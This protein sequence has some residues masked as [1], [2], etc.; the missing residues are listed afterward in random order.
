VCVCVRRVACCSLQRG[1]PGR[2]VCIQL[3]KCASTT[4][5]V[6]MCKS[7][8]FFLGERCVERPL[9]GT[10]LKCA[11]GARLLGAWW[12]LFEC[13]DACLPAA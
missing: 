6:Q 8:L 3:E 2:V 5:F 7:S 13:V 1:G 10:C 9:L 11:L 12:R 4:L